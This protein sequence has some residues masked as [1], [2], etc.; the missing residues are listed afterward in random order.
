MILLRTPRRVVVV[1]GTGAGTAPIRTFAAAVGD[2]LPSTELY[3]KVNLTEYYAADKSVVLLG[4]PGAFTPTVRPHTDESVNQSISHVPFG[5][6]LDKPLDSLI[7]LL[8]NGRRC[9]P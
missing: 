9:S 3:H 5:R 7:F 1:V 8:R 2:Q 6:G 4:L